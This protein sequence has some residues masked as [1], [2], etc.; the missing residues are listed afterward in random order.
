M[1]T[2]K[3]NSSSHSHASNKAHSNH[4]TEAPQA[5]KG[6]EQTK[7]HGK[8]QAKEHGQDHKAEKKDAFS[9]SKE[10]D[11]TKK[12]K[13]AKDKANDKDPKKAEEGK[14]QGKDQ[15]SLLKK[16]SDLQQQL[17][18]MKKNKKPDAPENL[19]G[20]C[21]HS[22]GSKKAE[23]PN[24]KD[25]P[26]SELTKLAVAILQ[27][28]KPQQA[29][30]GKPGEDKNG[31]KAIS[32]NPAQLKTELSQKYQQYKQQGVQLRPETEQ[33][34]ESALNGGSS[35]STNPTDNKTNPTNN[36][37]NLTNNKQPN[38]NPARPLAKAS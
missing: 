34:V 17:D 28:G 6:T 30:G 23:D 36:K 12:A 26:D 11:E 29:T 31:T 2:I 18:D 10:L 38:N 25:D 15:D 5:N 7:E 24:Q 27:G 13:D 33:L 1:S 19:G 20:C 32:G 8:E 4:K 14:D 35:T 22:H 9:A 3:H 37:T 16:I 21:G